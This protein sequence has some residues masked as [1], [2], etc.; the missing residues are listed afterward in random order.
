MP[1]TPLRTTRHTT[2]SIGKTRAQ[3]R[4]GGGRLLALPLTSDS[5][6]LARPKTSPLSKAQTTATKTPEAPALCG[7]EAPPQAP[8]PSVKLK[9][10]GAAGSPEDLLASELEECGLSLIH[11]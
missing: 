1:G 8:M 9:L 3:L 4:A 7:D 6:S 5:A 11:I 2:T 10:R